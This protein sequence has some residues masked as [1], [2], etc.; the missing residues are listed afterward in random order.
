MLN[1]EFKTKLSPEEAS[2]RV[3]SFFGKGGLGLEM[4]EESSGCLNFSGSGGFVNAIVC[5]DEGKTKIEL[6]SMEWE[7]QIQKFAEKMS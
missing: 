5:T 7:R 2:N 3:K 1:L 6:Q 4:D